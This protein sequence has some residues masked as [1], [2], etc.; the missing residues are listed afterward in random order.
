MATA[1]AVQMAAHLLRYAAS[2]AAFMR[3]AKHPIWDC[4]GSAGSA[5]PCSDQEGTA[6]TWLDRGQYQAPLSPAA[7]VASASSQVPICF[8]PMTSHGRL[9]APP[10][11]RFRADHYWQR[12]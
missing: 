8:A 5:W 9:P 6:T 7:N 12:C 10:D 2:L 4:S 1:P 11:R 3:A